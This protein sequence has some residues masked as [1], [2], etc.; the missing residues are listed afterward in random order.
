MNYTNLLLLIPVSL[1]HF[2][3]LALLFGHQMSQLSQVHT[4][5]VSD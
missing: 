5:L 3:L 2:I 4:H 1:A